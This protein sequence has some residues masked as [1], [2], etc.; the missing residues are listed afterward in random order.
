M[1]LV[2]KWHVAATAPPGAWENLGL[3]LAGIRRDAGYTYQAAFAA[4]R[5]PLTA[6]GNPNV[7]LVRDIESAAPKRINHFTEGTLRLAARAWGVTY[8]SV[9]AVLRGQADHLTPAAPVTPPA[10]LTAV[11]RARPG[12]PPGYK[13]P[14]PEGTRIAA[15]RPYADWIWDRHGTGQI[16]R[17][18]PARLARLW[19]DLESEGMDLP[20]LVWLIA[21]LWR[22]A[23]DREQGS[24]AAAGGG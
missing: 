21:D 8:E 22:R 15:D 16:P 9:L 10:P 2:R 23:D 7:R 14:L 12:E 1:P 24:H 19:G 11:P 5:L 3:Q 20:D 17:L 4:E 13:P 6:R 18:L